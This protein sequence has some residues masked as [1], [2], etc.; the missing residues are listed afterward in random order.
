MAEQLTLQAGKSYKLQAKTYN[1][2]GDVKY[3]NGTIEGVDGTVI[4]GPQRLYIRND[5]GF[6]NAVITKIKFV[7]TQVY[8]DQTSG[9]NENV[10]IDNNEF[11]GG[12]GITFTSGLKNSRITNNLFR[13]HPGHPV[14]GYNYGGLTVAN[15]ELINNGGGIHIDARISSDG[16]TID[17]NVT[18]GSSGIGYETQGSGQ[19]V[20]VTDNYWDK[21][22]IKNPNDCGAFSLILD[23]GKNIT[24]QR[25]TVLGQQTI[26][27]S[28]QCPRYSFEVGG[29]NTLASDN[30]INGAWDSF[31]NNDANL[32]TST[33]VK[34]NKIM[35][36]GLMPHISF[37]SSTAPIR[38]MDASNNGPNV[39]L[40]WDINRERPGRN[41]RLGT[42][43]TPTPS[44]TIVPPAPT[45]TVTIIPPTPTV[46]LTVTPS[47]TIAPK[48]LSEVTVSYVWSDGTKETVI[49]V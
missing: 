16:L 19:N 20:V 4:T 44:P 1:L 6:D 35:N 37:P 12:A 5:I 3:S 28:T 23:M 40:T 15:N 8:I 33:T 31:V 14:Y 17:Q 45:V 27:S 21:P 48:T 47:P 2:V 22:N 39:N 9:M 7:G 24:I 41:K 29:D 18:T 34:D 13:D 25:N 36:C 43:P 26:N 30:Y 49:R 10:V 42:T 32:T 11:W 38:K 46:T